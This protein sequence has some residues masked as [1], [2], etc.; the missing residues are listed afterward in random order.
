ML[1]TTRLPDMSGPEVENGNS[2]VVGFD[3]GSDGGDELAKKSEKSKSQKTS[4]SGKLAKS[5]KNSSKSEN[6]P[7]FGT[8]EIGP[9]FLTPKARSAFNPLRLAFTKAPIL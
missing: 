2:E 9:S 3:V 5:E 4:K 1:K 8:T 7:N 6:P